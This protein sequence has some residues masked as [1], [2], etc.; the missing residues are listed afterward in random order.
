MLPVRRG[1]IAPLMP[2]P[3]CAY[4]LEERMAANRARVQP[5]RNQ[6]DMGPPPTELKNCA[7]LDGLVVGRSL[8]LFS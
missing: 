3:P 1:T 6:Q 2:P 8:R 4:E 5:G 7:K